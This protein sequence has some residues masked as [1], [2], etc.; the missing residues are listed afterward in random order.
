MGSVAH[1]SLA[2]RKPAIIHRPCDE[3]ADLATHAVLGIEH[4]QSRRG[5]SAAWIY[6][7]AG[8]IED[9]APQEIKEYL[10][11]RPSNRR[12]LPEVPADNDSCGS[13]TRR[14]KKSGSKDHRS[15][16]Y[17]HRVGDAELFRAQE[18]LRHG[19]S[20]YH[21]F[22][23]DLG[24][25]FGEVLV[26]LSQ[27]SSQGRDLLLQCFH[28]IVSTSFIRSTNDLLKRCQLCL[29]FS[30]DFACSPYRALARLQGGLS[31]HL[32][33]TLVLECALQ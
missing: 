25:E 2:R 12:Q 27:L 17:D 19:G 26:D 18:Q 28:T 30:H 20:D 21:R 5:R 31:P 8:E 9:V 29:E 7:D 22:T 15:L 32:F 13:H 10:L 14:M 24:F 16:V 11:R 23:H 1:A 4:L 3:I 6:P 33:L